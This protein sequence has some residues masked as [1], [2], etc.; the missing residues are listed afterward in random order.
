MTL[1]KKTN[2]LKWVWILSAIPLWGCPGGDPEW[3]DPIGRAARESRALSESAISDRME[4]ARKASAAEE[5][6]RVIELLQPVVS[7]ASV[8]REAYALYGT[9]LLAEGRT[10]SAMWPLLRAAEDVDPNSEL[11]VNVAQALLRGGDPDASLALLDRWIDENPDSVNLHRLRIQGHQRR[12]DHEAALADLDVLIELTPDDLMARELRVAQ[13]QKVGESEEARAASAELYAHAVEIGAIPAL[14]ARFCSAL[15]AFDEE[16]GAVEQ[17]RVQYEECVALYPQE[18]DV[19]VG[20]SYFL[21][22]QGEVDAAIES[23]QEAIA[24]GGRLRQRLHIALGDQLVAAGR[25]EEAVAAFEAAAELLGSAQPLIEL[26]DHQMSWGEIEAASESVTRAIERRVGTRL[27]DSA[28][29]WL[30]IEPEL[31][32]AFADILIR[33]RQFDPVEQIIASLE[34]NGDETVYPLLLRARLALERRD[35]RQALE[36]F[37]ESFKTWPSNVGA[38]YLAGRAAMELGDFDLGLSLYQDAFRADTN[39]SDAGL[40]LA[41]LQLAQGLVLAAGQTLSTLVGNAIV[42]IPEAN[43]ML[44]NVATNLGAYDTAKAVRVGLATTPGWADKALYDQASETLALEGPAAALSLLEEEG[45]LV[46]PYPPKS[47][48]LWYRIQQDQG[49][50]DGRAAR[51]RILDLAERSP[52]DASLAIVET[53]VHRTGGDLEAALGAARRGAEVD[54][55]GAETVE[56][57]GRALMDL[58]LWDEAAAAFRQLIAIEPEGLAG[59][60]GL[61]DAVL[62]AG[63]RSEAERLYY[64]AL[65]THP[66]SG[67]AARILA[68]LALERED[69]GDQSIVWARWAARFNEGEEVP[70]TAILLAELRLAREEY[71]EAKTALR[72]AQESGA[73]DDPRSRYLMARALVGLGQPEEARLNLEAALDR[74]D[75]P[76][77]EQAAEL[78][79]EVSLRVEGGN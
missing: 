76:E 61:A 65:V 58:S 48:G 35:P 52:E 66:W 17:A 21:A 32:F 47:L 33:T 62:G 16:H 72:V 4:E 2:R 53:L 68:R 11:A 54:P 34:E 12:L 69:F 51:D 22:G 60:I 14:R 26:A 18:P 31:R 27:D 40:V 74:E 67:R 7:L 39:E 73:E 50:E 64:E 78:L 56:L 24:G 57:L 6:G 9:A 3:T 55:T 75:F 70:A 77:R 79:R 38:R 15:A 44:A 29:S 8:D 37:Q 59:R 45:C 63:D 5:F 36:L 10:S 30:S 23:L 43:R 41:R 25:R 1:R 28:F 13:L 49:E 19:L 42:D 71:E 46:A 20:R